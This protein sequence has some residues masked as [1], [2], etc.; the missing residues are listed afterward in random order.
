M[1]VAVDVDDD[2]DAVG[3]AVGVEN[4]AQV[5]ADD[6]GDA[7]VVLDGGLA[8][9]CDDDWDPVADVAAG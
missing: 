2:D 7:V 6:A 3:E 8:V 4:R 1:L 5:A 9:V